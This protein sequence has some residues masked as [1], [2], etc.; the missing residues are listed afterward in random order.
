ML[1][2]YAYQKETGGGPAP[3]AK[4]DVDF[5]ALAL[6][7]HD[8]ASFLSATGLT[9]TRATTSRVQTSS[10]AVS[11]SVATD[12]ACIGASNGSNKGLV[13]QPSTFNLVGATPGDNSPRNLTTAWTAGT[14]STTTAQTGA[15][16][17]AAATRVNAG[18]GG[19]GP[20]SGTGALANYC[21]S[22]FQRSTASDDMIMGWTDGTIPYASP[23]LA[24]LRAGNAAFGRLWLA[25]L[26]EDSLTYFTTVEGRDTSARGGAAAAAHDVVVDFVQ[27]ERGSVPTEPIP[28]G[29]TARAVDVLK[30]TKGEDQIS[31][32]GTLRF[33]VAFYP[34]FAANKTVYADNGTNF[35]IL[36]YWY[37]WAWDANNY[38]RINATTRKIEVRIDG[39]TYTSTGTVGWA[40]D[41]LVELWIVAGGGED[42]A[43]FIQVNGDGWFKLGEH[44]ALSSVVFTG[45]LVLFKRAVD[46]GTGSINTGALLSRVK[47]VKFY[48][49]D[50][51]PAG[52][53]S[54]WWPQDDVALTSGLYLPGGYSTTGT[55]GV[56]EVGVWADVSGDERDF[57]SVHADTAPVQHEGYP[58]FDGVTG[59]LE[60][61]LQSINGDFATPSNGAIISVAGHEAP[62]VAHSN[63]YYDNPSV[64][65]GSGATPSMMGDDA[66]SAFSGY[67]NTDYVYANRSG[68]APDTSY[69]LAGKWD[70]VGLYES[71]DS[72]W[73]TVVPYNV[74][75]TELSGPNIG[76]DT[77][78]GMGYAYGYIW[79]GPIKAVAFYPDAADVDNAKLAQW[80]AW[81]YSQGLLLS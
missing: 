30:T 22:S 68:F 79:K 44:T 46:T 26:A 18:S 41:D 17:T 7:G 78:I 70:D 43:S 5:S 55:A 24:T 42:T 25:S 19:Y 40:A 49:A 23:S 48:D 45:D 52:V 53:A 76:V 75:Q 77:Y 81:A 14:A 63:P 73:S 29:Q 27:F 20:Y 66:G 37:L 12:A 64:M 51:E 36:D 13:I 33:Y 4:L 15:D 32:D 50:E 38:A 34:K 60:C 47:H 69:V 2:V 31:A 65:S 56:D 59:G 80:K 21:F 11:T 28:T 10:S 6:G 62:L 61:A 1:P 35:T 71:R 39:S 9:F 16:G 57:V 8:A 3:P 67:D 54:A 72:T 58:V 74:G